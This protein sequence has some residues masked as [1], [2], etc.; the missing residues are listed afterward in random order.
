MLSLAQT[1]ATMGHDRHCDLG[2][3]R[4]CRASENGLACCSAEDARHVPGSDVSKC[5]RLSPR[6]LDSLDH[7]V[8]PSNQ[9]GRDLKANRCSGFEIDNQLD[10]YRMLDGQIGRLL[11]L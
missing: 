2:A 1:T 8:G 3:D 6:K 11:A 7:I 4:V 10:F 5:N 9:R